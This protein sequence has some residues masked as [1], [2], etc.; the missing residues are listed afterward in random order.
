MAL[1][2][3]TR[4][5]RIADKR[6]WC[7]R[8]VALDA[9]PA[10]HRDAANIHYNFFDLHMEALMQYVWQFRLWPSEYM[11]T[12]DGR[13]VHVIDPGLHN[14]DA[15]PDFFNAK[16]VIDG[17]QWVG[18]VEI[19]VRASDWVRHGHDNDRAYD[20]VVLH[21]VEYDDMAIHRPDG[22][23]IPQ[24][25]MKCAEDFAVK[26]NNMVNNTF[27]ELPCG[28]EIATLP[29]LY[30]TDWLSA[31][32]FER[33]Y[34]KA[35]RIH[36]ILQA[37][38]SNWAETIY[39]TL[40]RALGFGINSQ[41]FELLAKSM[42][43]KRLLQHTDNPK[44]IEAMLFGQAGFL[45][46]LPESRDSYTDTLSAEYAFL[47]AKYGLERSPNI[48]WKMARMRPQ[49]SPHRRI[50]A[51]A[52]IVADGFTISNRM[53]ETQSEADARALFDI[54]LSGYWTSH[55]NFASDSVSASIKA[56]S[57]S[58]IN[59]LLI[60]VVIPV[61][62]AYGMYTGDERRQHFAV[63]FMQTLKPESNHIIDVFTAAGITVYDAFTSQAL[64]QLKREYCDSRKCLYCRIGHK[65]LSHKVPRHCV[66]NS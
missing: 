19:H 13:R 35:E 62:F 32:A 45:D 23:L 53:I 56:L 2:R 21:V 40:A 1:K 46:S 4:N 7:I 10:A 65:L 61:I 30:I 24:L 51:L 25:V 47:R 33:L 15:G 5:V 34:A 8:K 20:T 6:H 22:Q 3:S 66:V 58:S 29:Q 27:R 16:V 55:Y 31:L 60:N 63:D 57:Q 50:A 49:N 48:V 52:S 44:Q 39:I 14:H 28:N 64:I 42:P 38:R 11:V 37:N 9:R 12:T 36:S 41:P 43:L 17:Q 18:N 59:V 26:Y 54:K